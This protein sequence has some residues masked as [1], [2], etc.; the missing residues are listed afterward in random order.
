MNMKKFEEAERK[1]GGRFKT[2]TLIQKRLTEIAAAGPLK[3]KTTSTEIFDKILD[4]IIS[5]QITINDAKSE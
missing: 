4:E 3:D 2:V 1:V 5:G